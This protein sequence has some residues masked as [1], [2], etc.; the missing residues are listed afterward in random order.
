MALYDENG[1]PVNKT[2]GGIRVITPAEIAE[3]IAFLQDKVN[4]WCKNRSGEKFC[5]ADFA[6]GQQRDWSEPRMRVIY[7]GYLPNYSG[8]SQVEAERKANDAA[9]KAVG[10]LL[11]EVLKSD[12]R[13]FDIWY[14][15][16]KKYRLR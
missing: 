15:G 10:R 8:C 9:S 14:G 12:S 11:F 5:A 6:G 7:E 1:K 4:W 2:Q 3:G 16:A 13:G